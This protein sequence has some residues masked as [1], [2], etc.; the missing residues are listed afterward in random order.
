MSAVS[1]S[2]A[3]R[4]TLGTIAD[5]YGFELDP[6]FAVH[7]TVTALADTVDSVT[8]GSLYIGRDGHASD[9]AL[10]ARRGAYA[11]MLPSAARDEHHGDAGIPLLFGRIDDHAVADLASHLAGTP[12]GAMAV[13]AV[14]GSD[15]DAVN[16][17]AEELADFLH[18]L[19]NPVAMISSAGSMSMTRPLN[20]S[21]PMGVLDVQRAF[22][23]C[24][25]DG[26]AAVIL[27]LNNVTFSPHALECVH[28]DVLG[29]Q[30]S[31]LNTDIETLKETYGFETEHMP[32]LIVPNEESYDM[33][34]DV[35]YVRGTDRASHLSLAIA[36]VLSAGV[37]R[38]NVRSA[39][40]VANNLN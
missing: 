19:G 15:D 24:A 18:M 10:A 6:A 31:Q 3:Q 33:L 36:M 4:V 20:L 14:V 22:A 29:A 7:V 38:N 27:T 21:Y 28:V 16:A 37:R 2:I 35:S 34:R 5:H 17:D 26:V 30:R 1:E 13:F 12:S 9:V 23:I 40:R 11:A 8:P 25:E 39:L 32:T